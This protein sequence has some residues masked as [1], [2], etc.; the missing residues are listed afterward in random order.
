LSALRAVAQVHP[1]RDVVFADLDS[2]SPA[3]GWQRLLDAAASH[4]DIAV[5]SASDDAT[6]AWSPRLS[7]WRAIALHDAA[8]VRIDFLP[9][10]IKG[11]FVDSLH[12]PS[13]NGPSGQATGMPAGT[14]PSGLRRRTA[15]LLA[16]AQYTWKASR[17]ALTRTS[18]SLRRRGLRNTISRAW[19][20]LRGPRIAAAAA[21]LKIPAST[22]FAPF[23]VPCAAIPVASIVVP[24]WNHFEHTLACLRALAASGDATAFEVIVVDDASTDGT[25]ARLR[26]I[27]GVRCLRNSENLGFIGASNAGAA[28]ARGDYL[29]FLNN[30]TAV[31]PGWRQARVSRWS[32]AGSRRGRV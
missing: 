17:N 16:S 28:I 29:V 18:A 30:D 26:E 1:Q 32:I 13:S 11:A 20:E 15:N 7:Y 19:L 2:G 10:E 25:A 4:P 27:D 5:L 24:A 14:T 8:R 12:A 9:S 23:A 31:Q 22:A 21:T 6:V 3:D